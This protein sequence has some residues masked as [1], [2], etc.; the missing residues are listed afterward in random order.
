MVHAQCH[1]RV[2][3]V[4][5]G[6]TLVQCKDGLVDHWHQYPVGDKTGRIPHFDGR[7]AQTLAE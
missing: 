3:G 4:G 5:V 7:F 6:N 2:D 1:Y